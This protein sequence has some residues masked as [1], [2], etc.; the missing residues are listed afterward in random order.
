MKYLSTL[1]SLANLSVVTFKISSVI[2]LKGKIIAQGYNS[3]YGNASIHAEMAALQKLA[4]LYGVSPLLHSL[5]RGKRPPCL[6][7]KQIS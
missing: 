6:L 5:L 3:C 4:S 1:L 7:W 2:V